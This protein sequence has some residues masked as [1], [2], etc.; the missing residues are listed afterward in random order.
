[1]RK[2]IRKMQMCRKQTHAQGFSALLC[3]GRRAQDEGRWAMEEG[4]ALDTPSLAW[5]K[6]DGGGNGILGHVRRFRTPTSPGHWILPPAY[7]HP[8]RPACPPAHVCV[9]FRQSRKMAA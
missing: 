3:F 5:P 8:V 2:D 6:V 4:L 7:V 9:H 1:M